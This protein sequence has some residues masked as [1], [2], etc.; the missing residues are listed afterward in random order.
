VGSDSG[1]RGSESVSIDMFGKA[2]LT[3]LFIDV[4]IYLWLLPVALIRYI[5]SKD[6]V[7]NQLIYL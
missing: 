6:T 5:E 7:I 3:T 2:A 4:V 1:K